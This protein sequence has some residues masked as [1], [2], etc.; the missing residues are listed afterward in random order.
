MG[1]PLATRFRAP[2]PIII[3]HQRARYLKVFAHLIHLTEIHEY[4]QSAPMYKS[5]GRE[6]SH[7]NSGPQQASEVIR[8]DSEHDVRTS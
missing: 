8:E 1:S 3:L 2:L 6:L 4:P 7:C 5:E